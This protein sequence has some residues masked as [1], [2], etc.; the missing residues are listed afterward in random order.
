MIPNRYN[1]ENLRKLVTKPSILGGEIRRVGIAVNRKVYK[2]RRADRIDIF[3]EDWDNLLILDGCRYD[4]FAERITIAGELEKRTSHTSHSTEFISHNFQGR[5]HHDT[6]YITTNPY[7]REIESDTFYAQIDLLDR[8]DED[9][10]TVHPTDVVS[11]TKERSDLYS[12]KRLIVHFMQPHYP[13]IGDTGKAIE[14]RGFNA[15]DSAST[16]PSIWKAM[17]YNTLDIDESQL[18]TAYRENLDI[19]LEE[20]ETLLQHLDGK[21]VITSDHGNLLGERLPPLYFKAYGHPR[22]VRC[23]QLN[24]LPWFVPTFESRRRIVADDPVLSTQS[25]EN[26][27]NERL[28]A[29]GYA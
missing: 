15:G 18:V 16:T 7:V 8:W 28:K 14:H 29:L 3:E 21:T 25:D 5:Q 19:V 4:C 17:M 2:S 13:F 20:V 11:A 9:S 22:G 10:Q 24:H 6:V 23:P 27:L 12:D 1:R 26:K